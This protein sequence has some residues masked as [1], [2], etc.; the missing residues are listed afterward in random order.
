M[1]GQ[2][3]EWFVGFYPRRRDFRG[4]WGHVECWGYTQHES[5]LFFDPR[6]GCAD[7]WVTHMHDE[8]INLLASRFD[9]CNLILKLPPPER[10]ARASYLQLHTCASAVGHLVGVRASTPAVLRRRLLGLG[11]EIVHEVSTIGRRSHQGSECP[12]EPG[13]ECCC[14]AGGAEERG[15][16]DD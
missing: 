14:I 11:A 16:P 3:L 12:G 8:V 4:W 13:R 7:V 1:T 2:V 10:M 5:W 9:R 6:H 15:D